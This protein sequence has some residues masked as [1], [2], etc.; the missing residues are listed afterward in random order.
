MG[1]ERPLGVEE[2]KPQRREQLFVEIDRPVHP[3]QAKLG[4]KVSEIAFC[5]REAFEFVTAQVVSELSFRQA[6][7]ALAVISAR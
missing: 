6:G 5:P 4:G 2:M 3:L 1:A 7:T